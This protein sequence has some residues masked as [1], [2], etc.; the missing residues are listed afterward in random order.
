MNAPYPGRSSPTDLPIC[1]QF[2]PDRQV[3][4]CRG[5]EN[6]SSRLILVIQKETKRNVEAAMTEARRYLLLVSPEPGHLLPARELGIRLTS[7]GAI[8]IFVTTPD[9]AP[10]VLDSALT[11][12]D[13][14]GNRID[15]SIFHRKDTIPNTIAEAPSGQSFW[16]NFSPAE[17]LNRGS[18]LDRTLSQLLEI[19][20]VDAVIVDS[21][22]SVRYH[23][24]L[25][26]LMERVPVIRLSTSLPVWAPQVLDIGAY[27]LVLCP[28]EFELPVHRITRERFCYGFPCV[29]SLLWNDSSS[30]AFSVLQRTCSDL[31]VV[32]FGTQTRLHPQARERL[33]AI[34]AWAR[35]NPSIGFIIGAGSPLLTAFASAAAEDLLNVVVRHG[36]PQVA[37]L[38]DA[39]LLVSHGGLGS[40]KEAIMAG[41]PMLLLPVL[42]DQ[43]QNAVR[44][45]HFGFGR[46]IYPDEFNLDLVRSAGMHL[47][48]TPHYRNAITSF[49]SLF[50]AYEKN[51]ASLEFIEGAHLR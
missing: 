8:V 24:D 21:I 4:E 11:V 39:S 45:E 6:V 2:G 38:Q 25:R 29:S 31:V 40:I 49:S 41:V 28:R 27:D 33:S 19:W 3:T 37:L 22:L 47:L 34:L 17:H 20:E 43:P 44:I 13:F 30:A 15:N 50:K 18:L 46:A 1:P 32:S 14:S 10:L 48:V 35:L 23:A 51:P 12:I 5:F 36:I 26:L 42:A 9:L 7:R 16:F